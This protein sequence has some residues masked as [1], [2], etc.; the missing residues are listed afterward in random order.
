MVE[1]VGL[2]QLRV[3][4]EPTRAARLESERSRPATGRPS[5]QSSRGDEVAI[6]LQAAQMQR[7]RQAVEA[8]PEI[9]QDK[10]EEARRQIATG[11]YKVSSADIARRV[12]D[13]LG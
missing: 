6:S 9:R 1:G 4:T 12:L 5:E 13:V 11:Q 8:A 10:V 2:G 3:D 7:A